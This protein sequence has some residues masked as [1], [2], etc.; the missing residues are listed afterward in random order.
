MAS[1]NL[2]KN[3]MGGRSKS[4]VVVAFIRHAEA[5]WTN[6]RLPG[7]L[8]G[9][10]LSSKGHEQAKLLAEEL[11]D[12]PIAELRSSP[13]ERALQTAAPLSEALG[14]PIVK[15]PDLTE[16][17]CGTWA[18][19]TFRQVMRLRSYKELAVNPMLQRPPQGETILEVQTRM[20]RF[21]ER[22]RNERPGEIV[23]AFSHADPIKSAVA[24][25]LGLSL[26][27]YRRI[28]IGV[29]SVAAF[30]LRDEPLMLCV[31]ADGR[32]FASAYQNYLEIQKLR[33]P[34]V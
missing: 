15:D 10:R 7:R 25:L 14:I 34:S 17:D 21:V 2:G 3:R 22:M 8:E 29:A 20:M 26:E 19:K 23:A 5:I 31:N 1:S 4:P 24:G 27:M 18:G 33:K 28:E 9:V 32:R 30:V 11:A 12:L 6:K 13:L 16:A